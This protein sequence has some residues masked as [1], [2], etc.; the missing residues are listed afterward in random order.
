MTSKRHRPATIIDVARIAGV[1]K[2]TVARVLAG[3]EQVDPTTRARVEKAIATSGY[4]RNHLAQGLRTG[5]TRMLGLVIPDIANP[6]WADVARGAQDAAEKLGWSVLIVNSDW[7]RDREDRHLRAL[8]QGRVDAVI[9]NPA[10]PSP[11]ML[12]TLGCPVV[13]IGSGGEDFPEFSSVRSNAHQGVQLAMAHLHRQG[14][15]T[16]ALLVGRTRPAARARFLGVVHDVC[17]Q[18]GIAPH[19]LAIEDTDYSMAAGHAAMRRLLAAADRERPSAVFAANDLMALGAMTA[20]REAGLDC[21]RDVSVI[22]MDGIAAGALIAPG[23]TSIE[24]PRYAIGTESAGLAIEHI[25]G[26]SAARHLVLPC[27][28]IERGSVGARQST[29]LSRR[30]RA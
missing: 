30:T 6:Y 20:L 2:T 29:L 14:H 26:R 8:R 10:G 15:A 19:S 18:Q 16:P 1:S 17:R 22:G 25:E 3:G 12:R 7:D 4:E 28:L 13:L 5:R 23:L 21:P 27:R 9:V 11:D 24:K